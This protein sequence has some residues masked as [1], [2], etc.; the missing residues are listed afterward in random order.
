[1]TTTLLSTPSLDMCPHEIADSAVN[2]DEPL[3]AVPFERGFVSLAPIL[4]DEKL[5]FAFLP[6]EMVR[7][8]L[9]ELARSQPREPHKQHRET[10]YRIITVSGGEHDRA[11]L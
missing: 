1:M 2:G 7:P 10:D 8:C 11:V 5:E 3:R 4:R 6:A 9:D